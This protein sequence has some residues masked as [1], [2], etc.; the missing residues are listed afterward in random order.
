ME[1]F[2]PT[3]QRETMREN[4]PPDMQDAYDRIVG[5]GMKF[6]FDKS[7]HGEVIKFLTQEGTLDEKLSGGVF[8]LMMNMVKQSNGSMPQELIIP[9]GIDLILQAAEFAEQTGIDQV[10]PE[11]IANAIQKYVFMVAK[12]AGISEEQVMGG[13]DKLQSQVE[14]GAAPAPQGGMINQGA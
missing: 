12:K 1:Q 7:T 9:A 6:M 2:N 10:T 13:I 8:Y 11:I 3:E 4:V 14:G 5:A